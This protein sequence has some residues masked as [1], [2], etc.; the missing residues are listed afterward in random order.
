MYSNCTSI[1]IF[2]NQ[3]ENQNQKENKIKIDASSSK[4]FKTHK[5]K[6]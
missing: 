1:K 3:K 6:F 2:F 5:A 4:A